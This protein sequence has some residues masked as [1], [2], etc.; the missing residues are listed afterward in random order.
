MKAGGVYF[1]KNDD[2]YDSLEDNLLKVTRSGVRGGHDDVL[3]AFAWLGLGLAEQ[4][5]APTYQ[6]L[7]DEEYEELEEESMDFGVSM[8]TGY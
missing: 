1:N 2:N 6:E 7:E 3:D 8:V 5:E 4:T